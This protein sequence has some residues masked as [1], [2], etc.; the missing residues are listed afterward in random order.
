MVSVVA[1]C[2]WVEAAVQHARALIAG[3][4]P[5]RTIS[6]MGD[7]AAAV[8]LTSA[9]SCLTADMSGTL[10]ARHARFASV[11]AAALFAAGQADSWL[12]SS[13][14]AR[15]SLFARTPAAQRVILTALRSQL[16]ETTEVMDSIKQQSNDLARDVHALQYELPEAPLPIQPQP[17]GPIVW[18]LRPEGTFG[19]YRCSI[20]YPDLSVGTYWSPTDD[21]GGS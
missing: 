1:Q 10:V 9:T 12:R 18:C 19:H 16:V 6:S 21:T 2:R 7:V 5:P 20:L 4:S 13:V 3:D 14:G 11:N 17:A 8:H 15:A